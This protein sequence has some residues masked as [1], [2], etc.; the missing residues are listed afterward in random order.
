MKSLGEVI[1]WARTNKGAFA[2]I[3]TSLIEAGVSI[4]DFVRAPGSKADPEATELGKEM[5]KYVKAGPAVSKMVAEILA[6][7]GDRLR[8]ELSGDGE[9]KEMVARAAVSFI[10]DRLLI[11]GAG[12]GAIASMLELHS[13]LQLFTQM[14][15]GDVES[16]LR[17]QLAPLPQYNAAAMRPYLLAE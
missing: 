6:S 7:D 13:A 9:Q 8:L 15:R 5:S 14:K 3:A 4:A 11:V 17:N 10:R 12:E 1:A 16:L 2:L